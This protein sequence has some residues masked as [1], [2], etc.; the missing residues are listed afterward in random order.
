VAID[1]YLLR[2]SSL[3]A[4]NAHRDVLLYSE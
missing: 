2:Y 3:Y 1:T 4:Q